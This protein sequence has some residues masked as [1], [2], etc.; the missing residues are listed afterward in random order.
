MHPRSLPMPT[1]MQKN[2]RDC[3]PLMQIFLFFYAD[4]SKF[5]DFAFFKG[6][7]IRVYTCC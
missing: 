5:Y 2:L 1:K 7:D 3:N 6:N 4:F